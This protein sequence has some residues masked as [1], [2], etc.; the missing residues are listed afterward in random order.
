MSLIQQHEE[1]MQ[2]IKARKDEIEAEL[3]EINRVLNK[4]V[5]GTPK[6]TPPGDSITEEMKSKWRKALEERAKQY[7]PA[8][9]PSYSFPSPTLR[10]RLDPAEPLV[11]PVTPP[12]FC[13]DPRGGMYR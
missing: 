6:P 7:P 8:T 3:A 13:S 1:L 9:W 4:N 12:L 5:P 11:Q 2:K 10:P